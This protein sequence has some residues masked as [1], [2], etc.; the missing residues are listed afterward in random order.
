M[1]EKLSDMQFRKDL[2]EELLLRIG[3]DD[4]I[5]G[6]NVNH[7]ALFFKGQLQ[8]KEQVV[9]IRHAVSLMYPKERQISF[10]GYALDIA[11]TWHE[12]T[13]KV[14]I[15]EDENKKETVI[16]NGRSRV[17]YYGYP[18]GTCS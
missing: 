6:K 12:H 18:E 9:V 17:M 16:E 13:W 1:R 11:G 7:N 10:R 2:V 4:V 5:E 8:E 3:G 15:P 14:F